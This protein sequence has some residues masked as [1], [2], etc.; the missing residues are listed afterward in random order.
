MA[1]ART[2]TFDQRARILGRMLR[3]NRLVALLRVAVP[4]LGVAAFLLL[5]G[6][7][8]LA[9]ITRQ[10]GVSGIRVDRGNLVV[11]TPRYAGTGADGARYLVKAREARSPLGGTRQ[12]VLTDATLD[13]AR[14]GRTTF[15]VAAASATLDTGA[16]RVDIPGIARIRADDGLHGTLSAVEADIGGEVTTAKG[17]VNLTFPDGTT[18]TAAS[19][20]FDGRT[21]TWTFARSTLTVPALP[22]SA[23]AAG[24]VSP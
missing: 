2:E 16:Q 10:Y 4:A 15:H 5:A 11:E 3:R 22:A 9:N 17:P 23:N 8:W 21:Q 7:I 14:P 20:H 24:E 1:F 18:L 13:Y 6:Q 19:M 12:I